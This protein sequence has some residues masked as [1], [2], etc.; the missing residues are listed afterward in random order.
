[1]VSIGAYGKGK[2]SKKPSFY[3][4]G[5]SWLTLDELQLLT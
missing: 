3:S 4:E 2:K 5:V 1:M